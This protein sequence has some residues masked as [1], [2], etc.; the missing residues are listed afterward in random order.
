MLDSGLGTQVNTA[1]HDSRN[2]CNTLILKGRV[3]KL[4]AAAQN[5]GRKVG[6]IRVLS[7]NET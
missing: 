7:L 2:V 4:V 1:P 3:E 5:T 6:L